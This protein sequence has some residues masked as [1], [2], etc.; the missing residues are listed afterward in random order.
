MQREVYHYQTKL[1]TVWRDLHAIEHVLQ[2]IGKVNNH[3]RDLLAALNKDRVPRAWRQFESNVESDESDAAAAAAATAAG[4]AASVGGPDFARNAKEVQRLARFTRVEQF[5]AAPVLLGA[6]LAPQAF[7]AATRQAVAQ[8]HNWSLE[9]LELRVAV[10]DDDDDSSSAAASATTTSSSS[11]VGADSFTF[12]GLALHGAAW[13]N[14]ALAVGSDMS[15]P[16]PPVRF[17]WVLRKHAAAVAAAAAAATVAPPTSRLPLYLDST[18]RDFVLSVELRRPADDA[19]PRTVWTQRSVCLTC[20][21]SL[22]ESSAAT[23]KSPSS[24]AADNDDDDADD[25]EL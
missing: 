15:E 1:A 16:L 21:T 20:W 22:S 17:T 11:N 13:R 12:A 5:R 7:V 25:S 6:L 23:T 4:V 8:E 9:E 3:V 19:M 2:G 18:R 10:V 24:S 14:G